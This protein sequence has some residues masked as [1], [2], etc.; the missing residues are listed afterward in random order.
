MKQELYKREK[1][2]D[3]DKP[4]C[5]TCPEHGDFW[6]TPREHLEGI[7]CPDCMR[8]EARFICNHNRGRRGDEDY[9][10]ESLYQDKNGEF[11]I[12]GESAYDTIYGKN[13]DQ[14]RKYGWSIIPISEQYA[15]LNFE[16][17]ID[18]ETYFD[19]FDESKF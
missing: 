12:Y 5:I 9:Y 7:G 13:I 10:F 15:K 17:E 4:V 1:L 3:M 16:Q 11:F 18:D 19:L 6:V 14:S 2:L 8:K